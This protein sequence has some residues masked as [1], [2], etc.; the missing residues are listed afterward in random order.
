METVAEFLAAK[1]PAV[2]HRRPN[3]TVYEALE[4]MAEKEHRRRDRD[5]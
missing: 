3:A 4:L 1:G 2:L 5:R